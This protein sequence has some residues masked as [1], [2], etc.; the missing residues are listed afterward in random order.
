MV[1]KILVAEDEDKIRTLVRRYLEMEGFEV[2]EAEDGAEALNLFYGH[3]D[4]SM[5]ML[6]VMMPKLDGLEV[7]KK[8]REESD[9]PVLML[10]ARSAEHDELTGFHLG[11]DEYIS[12]PFSLSILMTRVKNLLK[13]SDSISPQNVEFQGLKLNYKER[14]VTV[15]GERIPL[16][17]REFNLLYYL[18]M[19]RNI[20]LSR[21]K[22]ILTVWEMDYD[23][24][25]RTVDTHIKCLRAKLKE[26]GN[27]IVTVRKV[28]Y[29]FEG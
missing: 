27:H 28:G 11:A 9:V 4:L 25:D 26:Y 17:P 22:I 10:T 29:K 5:V 23:G 3:P 15:D 20:V 1:A 16:T 14:T 8:I 19:N 13:R 2:L 7:L 6:D 24:D 21:E 12:K 18:M